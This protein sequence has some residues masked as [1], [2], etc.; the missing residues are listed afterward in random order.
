MRLLLTHGFFLSEDA[1][2]QQVMRPYPPLGLLYISAY[3]R[4][5][6]FEVEVYD[7]TFGSKQELFSI[8]DRGPG[9]WLG[10]YGNL[11][12]RQNVIEIAKRGRAAGWQVVLG[13]PEPAN[14]AEQYLDSG[15][16][17]IVPSEGEL[18]LAKL[19]AGDPAPPGVIYRD[20]SGAIVRT[21][22][23]TLLPDLDRLPW[24]DRER[25]DLRQYL[26]AWRVRHGKGSV[27]LIT[28]RGCPYHCR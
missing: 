1:K 7:S 16:S 19:L 23:E 24:P 14:Y 17:Y 8:L 13:G 3:L 10:C 15:A 2:E 5:K 26:S 20:P 28:A 27:S 4:A 12:T 25:I 6:G 21:P 22:P 9:G 18:T 11:L